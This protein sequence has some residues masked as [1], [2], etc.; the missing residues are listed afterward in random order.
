MSKFEVDEAMAVASLIPIDRVEY[1]PVGVVVWLRYL[2]HWRR[3]WRLWEYLQVGRW[4]DGGVRSSGWWH[5]LA[6]RVKG[7]LL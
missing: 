7:W 1:M 4:W 6:S 5:S 3:M 2:E